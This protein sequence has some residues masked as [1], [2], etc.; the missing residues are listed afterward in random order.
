MLHNSYIFVRQTATICQRVRRVKRVK[1]LEEIVLG[2]KEGL[3]PF[4]GEFKT[5]LLLREG[6]RSCRGCLEILLGMMKI[7]FDR[8][9]GEELFERTCELAKRV[10]LLEKISG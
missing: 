7:A 9:T 1:D 5:L 2:T 6:T 3:C 8:V 4:C 10:E